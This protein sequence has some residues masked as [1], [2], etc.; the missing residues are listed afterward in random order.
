[1]SLRDDLAAALSAVDGVTGYA[2]PP[3]TPKPGDA[4]PAL[5]SL[6]RGPGLNFAA[7]WA[8]HVALPVAPKDAAE[9]AESRFVDLVVGIADVAYTERV[10]MPDTATRAPYLLTLAL[11]AEA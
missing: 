4:W 2:Q 6:E 10:I 8:V 5:V 3:T 1:M 11:L 7:A 9:W